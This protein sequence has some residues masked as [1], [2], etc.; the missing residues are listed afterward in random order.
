MLAPRETTIVAAT[1]LTQAVLGDDNE[2]STRLAELHEE[3]R[4]IM[5]RSELSKPKDAL[6]FFTDVEYKKV[7]GQQLTA[8]CMFCMRSV[9]LYPR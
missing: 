2:A 6:L 3:T 9:T 1:P 5:S 8:K 7:G 4:A